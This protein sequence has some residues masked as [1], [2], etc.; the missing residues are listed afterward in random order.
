MLPAVAGDAAY[1]SEDGSEQ[2]VAK[3]QKLS[4]VVQ[5]ARGPN[6]LRCSTVG[7]TG[8]KPALVLK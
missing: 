2:R 6:Q 7:T 3:Q 5:D 1:S 8:R 4:A